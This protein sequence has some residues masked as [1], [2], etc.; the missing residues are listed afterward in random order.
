MIRF[1]RF[2]PLGAKP[3]EK[4]KCGIYSLELI[5]GAKAS[6]VGEGELGTLVFC[7]YYICLYQDF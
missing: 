1:C 5:F 3:K 7:G 4:E 6:E 2:W